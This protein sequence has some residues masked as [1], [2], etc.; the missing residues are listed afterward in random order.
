M[1]QDLPLGFTWKCG[2]HLP[3]HSVFLIVGTAICFFYS[4]ELK[5]ETNSSP[6]P[7]TKR[8]PIQKEW[9]TIT[10][11]P[12]GLK[13]D[14][15]QTGP[16]RSIQIP[17][18]NNRIK[19]IYFAGDA[20]K[21][22]LILKPGIQE[23][24]IQ[25]PKTLP[26]PASV[27]V[28]FK[29]PP[30]LSVKPKVIQENQQQQVILDAKDAVVHGKLLRYEPQPH[31]NTV[32]YWANENDWCEWKLDLKTPGVFDV[33]LLQGCGKGQGGSEVQ[34]SVADQ[35]LK[36]T[37][38]DT[39]HFQNFKERHIGKLK[40]DKTGVQTL[41]LKPLQKARNAVMDVR[42]IRLVRQ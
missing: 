28:A 11:L 21:K 9:G 33:Y 42:Q 25:L 17:R 8:F 13:L 27:I 7:E 4:F 38:E 26:E 31:K 39:G 41:Q 22:R 40:I 30:Y 23:W 37:V 36:F 16:L 10:A 34:L 32:G 14:I 2:K 24:E 1:I 15:L 5:A 12:Q 18:M 29:E 3:S 6:Q 19:T 20:E 35:N